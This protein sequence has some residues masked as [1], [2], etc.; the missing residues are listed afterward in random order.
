M[1]VASLLHRLHQHV[2]NLWGA[3]NG[4]VAIIFTIALIPI[5][6][7]AGG[8]IDYSRAS[9]VKA[10]MQAALDATAL[11]MSKEATTLSASAFSEKAA[12]YFTAA[13]NRPEAQSIKVTASYS[14]DDG[15]SVT[16]TG[17]GSIGTQFLGILGINEI[18]IGSYAKT[19][20]GSTRLR[21][22]LV[23]DNTGSMSSSGKMTALKAASKKLLTQLQNAASKPGDVY[24]SI[25][26]FSKDVNVGSSKYTANWVGWR[27]WEEVNGK[28][29]NKDYETRSECTKNL[30]NWLPGNHINWNGCVADRDQ[31]YDIKNTGPNPLDALLLP[32]LPSTLFPAE[33]YGSCPTALMPQSYDWTQLNQTIDD[34]YPA[35]TTNQ[36]IGLAW[37]WMSLTETAPLNAPAKDP[38]FKYRDVIILLTDGMNTQ[39]RW[40]SSQSSIDARQ[41][42]ICD[43]IKAAKITIYTILVM[44]GNST[45]LQNCASDSTKY[46]ALTSAEQIITAFDTIGTN[47]AQLRLAK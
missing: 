8:A 34:M 30:K 10:S 46:F 21:V 23:L 13:F 45:V 37:G 27:D 9:S 40:T 41:Q 47:L 5:V 20:W 3:E 18:P 7:L 31:S 38:K 17:S 32:P 36:P 14:A 29:S 39:N 6:G 25:I 42:M 43:N 44:A 12:A 4:N 28:C 15:S 16:V 35:G 11:A 33:Q 24:V 22:A 26:P 1:R 19:A 2:R